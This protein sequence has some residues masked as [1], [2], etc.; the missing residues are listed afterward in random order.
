MNSAIKKVLP[1]T[2]YPQV[3]AP[4]LAKITTYYT[5][6]VC[7]TSALDVLRFGAP[8]NIYQTGES[9]LK[10]I[11]PI[12][13][14]RLLSYV[15]MPISSKIMYPALK[16]LSVIS[17]A[18]SIT[19]GQDTGNSFYEIITNIVQD[20]SDPISIGFLAFSATN[21]IPGVSLLAA[22]GIASAAGAA[23]YAVSELL[24]GESSN[25]INP[26]TEDL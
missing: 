3:L 8:Q 24:L 16:T 20:N 17:S 23:S 4:A 2:Y 15:N 13:T 12:I 25:E 10:I 7:L 6:S 1:D 22:I 21:A 26:Q 9:A 19:H 5:G 18:Y 11:V 14:H